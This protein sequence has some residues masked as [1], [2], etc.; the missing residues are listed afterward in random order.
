[1]PPVYKPSAAERVAAVYAEAA[2][3]AAEQSEALFRDRVR[4]LALATDYVR[5]EGD[6][7]E[8][9]RQASRF[10]DLIMVGQA[11]TEN[12]PGIEPFLLPERFIFDCAAPVLI[13][14]N[15][16]VAEAI[17]RS[18]LVGW[19]GSGQAARAIRDALPF[20]REARTVTVVAVDPDRQGHLMGGAHARAMV[21][22]LA[23]HGINVDGE[24]ILSGHRD[25][26]EVLLARA[27]DLGADMMVMGAY[28]HMRLKEFILGG[29]TPDI[30]EQ[31]AI[32]V[33][34]SH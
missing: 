26:A 12:P 14:P 18:V 33:L 3:K 19:D 25:A 11:D 21:A 28:G 23:R 10:G 7:A 20:L 15:R 2:H 34:M 31:T 32:P 13:V 6:I 1:V 4:N 16:F 27:A 5:A 8:H 30:V 22:R 24:D 17:G 9:L 29:T